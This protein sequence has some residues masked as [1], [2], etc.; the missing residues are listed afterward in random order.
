MNLF[1][2]KDNLLSDNDLSELNALAT[3]RFP[4]I[5]QEDGY[6]KQNPQYPIRSREPQFSPGHVNLP[7]EVAFRYGKPA[8][9]AVDATRKFLVC[10]CHVK[11]PEIVNIWFAYMTPDK[12]V[13]MHRD[14]PVRGLPEENAITA[15]FYIHKKWEDDWGGEIVSRSGDVFLP[16]P[17]RLVIW[18]RDIW[19]GVHP[20]HPTA[21]TN[22]RMMMAT[23][24]ISEGRENDQQREKS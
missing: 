12:I 9:N 24:W 3:R 19:H 22:T 17:N 2:Y 10:E 20:I 21:T 4:L 7:V 8:M 18:S 15:C 11:N 13:P 1:T 23:T 5:K 6:A 16:L 14:G